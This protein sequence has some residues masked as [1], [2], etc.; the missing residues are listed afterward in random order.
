MGLARPGP[1]GDRIS[2]KIRSPTAPYMEPAFIFFFPKLK[3]KVAAS[4]YPRG[5]QENSHHSLRRQ[6]FLDLYKVGGTL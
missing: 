5:V 3:K 6:V 4:P 1:A 2:V